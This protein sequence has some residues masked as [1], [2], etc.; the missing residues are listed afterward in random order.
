V[1]QAKMTFLR[2][3]DAGLQLTDA[4]LQTQVA[5]AKALGGG[6]RANNTN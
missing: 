5:L 3:Q 1:L 6:Y 4:R 2:Q